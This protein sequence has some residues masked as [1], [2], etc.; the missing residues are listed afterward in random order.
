MH[1]SVFV[2]VFKK[3][4]TLPLHSAFLCF[5]FFFSSEATAVCWVKR[6]KESV[7]QEIKNAKRRKREKENDVCVCK[8]TMVKMQVVTMKGKT[9][10]GWCRG[11]ASND[12]SDGCRDFLVCKAAELS[13]ECFGGV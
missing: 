3:E 5:L 7:T 9:V 6:K 13:A 4:Q 10:L 2:A 1:V 11:S 12:D 8:K